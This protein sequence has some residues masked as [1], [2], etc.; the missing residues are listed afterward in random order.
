MRM[1]AL[2]SKCC[3]I[4]DSEEKPKFSCK[5]VSKK[6][7]K[8]SIFRGLNRSINTVTNMG[9]WLY[10]QGIV[11]YTQDKLGLS[12]YYD[13]KIVDLDGIPTKLPW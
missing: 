2:T 13:K 11:T 7:V 5:G 9:F 12:A 8:G 1:I 6:Y 4:E 3:Y 10:E